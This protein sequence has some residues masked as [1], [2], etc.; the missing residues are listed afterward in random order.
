MF[1]VSLWDE[2]LQQL[3]GSAKT[4]TVFKVNKNV[5]IKNSNVYMLLM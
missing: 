2:E 3:Q 4:H 5:N 1:N